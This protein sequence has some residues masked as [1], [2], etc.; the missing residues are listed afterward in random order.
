M[1]KINSFGNNKKFLGF[2]TTGK[3]SVGEGLSLFK[4]NKEH[5][6]GTE[7]NR[8][9]DGALINLEGTAIIETVKVVDHVAIKDGKTNLYPGVEKSVLYP[10]GGEEGDT[11]VTV[12]LDSLTGCEVTESSIKFYYEENGKGTIEFFFGKENK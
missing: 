12:L 9:Y 8:A 10:D 1:K 2:N 5:I 4:E 6:I 3:V 7:L 11:G